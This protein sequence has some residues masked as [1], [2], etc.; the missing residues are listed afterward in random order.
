[1]PKNQS[2]PPS[3][4]VHPWEDTKN[5]WV[6]V[7]LDYAGPFMGKMFLIVIDSFSKWMDVFPLANSNSRITIESLRTCFATHGLPQICVTDNGTCFTSDQFKYFLEI[8]GIR[9]V[10]SAPYHPATNG[11]AERAVRTFKNTI[12]KLKTEESINTTVNRFLFS[13]RITPQTTTGK[14]PSELLMNRK[15]NSRLHILKPDVVTTKSVIS[16]PRC[17]EVNNE[18][19]VRNYGKGDKWITGKIVCRTGPISYK[20]LTDVGELRKHVDQ[21]RRNNITE[22]NHPIEQEP[23]ETP[24]PIENRRPIEAEYPSSTTEPSFPTSPQLSQP[25]SPQSSGPPP[26]SSPP[27]SLSPPPPPSMSSPLISPSPVISPTTSLPPVASPSFVSLPP[28]Q[29]KPPK[30][31]QDYDTS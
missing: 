5:P 29:R 17:F 6:R 28:R 15:L 7:H 24:T 14:S 10:T 8:N 20:V 3:A 18:V 25:T 16:I 31:L 26:S 13:Y 21:I 9:H 2:M 11:C 27:L 23:I 30:Y 4:P 22:M 1:M 19:W 12:K